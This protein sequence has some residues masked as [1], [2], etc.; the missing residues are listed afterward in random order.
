M[1]PEGR[2]GRDAGGLSVN[3]TPMTKDRRRDKRENENIAQVMD[4]MRCEIR[5][6]PL[7]TSIMSF[8]PEI[9]IYLYS[10]KL[11]HIINVFLT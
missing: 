2:K 10:N 9:M 5:Y 1:M 11:L 8:T 3:G 6:R 7:Q 4:V